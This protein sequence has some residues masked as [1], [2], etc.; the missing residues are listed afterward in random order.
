M[1]EDFKSF[2]I[3]MFSVFSD[4]YTVSLTDFLWERNDVL[5]RSD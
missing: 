4:L 1:N 5:I 2:N 3:R